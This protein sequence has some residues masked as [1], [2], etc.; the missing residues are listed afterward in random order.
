MQANAVSSSP[1]SVINRRI[2]SIDLLRGMV[3]IVM[4]LDH[5]RDFFHASAYL[6]NPTDLTHTSP[7]IFLTRWITHFC[8]SI[9]VLLAGTSASLYGAKRTKKELSFFLFTRGL[10]LVTA[11]IVLMSFAFTFNPEYP[12][13]GL[14]VLWA[15]GL[16]MISL[17][18]LIHLNV[19]LILIIGILLIAGHNTLDGITISGHGLTAFI[20][21]VLHAQ[22]GF[23][24]GQ[25]TIIVAYPIIPWIGVIAVGYAIGMLY[26]PGYDAKKRKKVLLNSGLAIIALFIILRGLNIYGD[27]FPWATQKNAVFTI[28]SFINTTKYPPSLLYLLMTLGPALVFLSLA[29]K[30]LSLISQKITVYGRV[31]MFYYLVHFYLVHLLAM[32]AAVTIGFKWSDMI[33]S[34]FPTF[35]PTLKGYGFH[36]VTVYCVWIGVVLILY[37]LC[38]WYDKYK[39]NHRSNKWL[40][41][42]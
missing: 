36:L 6:Y 14:Q 13:I 4:A 11:E 42:L 22:N 8:A 41:Y 3:M 37:P 31:P 23:I 16:S 32:I 33:L 2:E 15:I 21:S 30:P 5:I 17:S 35:S 29:E 9:F 40:S 26:L 27:P 34:T 10:W 24:L 1:A 39:R 18:I 19:R 28:L 20:W 38:T 25:H 7:Y 12:F